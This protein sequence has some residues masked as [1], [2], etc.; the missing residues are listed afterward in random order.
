[1]KKIIFTTVSFVII[2]ITTITSIFAWYVTNNDLS[3]D[4]TIKMNAN[5]SYFGG[6]KGTSDEPYLISSAKHLYNLAWLQD[7][8][9]F[10]SK[11]YYFKLTQNIDMSNLKVDGTISPIPTIGIDSH[12]FIGNFNGNG[13]KIDNLYV[14]T[15]FPDSNE[16]YIKPSKAIL[17]SHTETISNGEIQTSYNGMFGV[18]KKYNDSA[19]SASNVTDFTIANAKIE[20]YKNT[21]VGYICGYVNSNLSQVGVANSSLI[22]GQGVTNYDSYP[23][24][25]YGLIGDYNSSNTGIDWS[26]NGSSNGSDYGTSTDIRSLFEK[27]KVVS[28]TMISSNQMVLAKKYAIPFHFDSSGTLV[29]GSGTTTVTSSGNSINASNAS[30]IPVASTG[31][32]IG[33][34]SGGEIKVNEDYFDSSKVDFDKMKTA[35]NSQITV[36][37]DTEH[38]DKIKTY[39]KTPVSSDTTYR[40]G[41]TAMVLSGTSFGDGGSSTSFPSSNDNYLVVNNAKVGDW[42]GSLFIP[43]RGIWV[44]PTKPGR[45]EFVAINTKTNGLTNASISVIRLKRS[46]PK[47]YSTGFSNTTYKQETDFSNDMCGCIIYGGTNA[48]VPY[49]FG[50]DV[51]QEDIDNGYEFFITKYAGDDTGKNN[52]YFVY[53]DVGTNSDS[54]SDSTTIGTIKDIDYTYLNDDKSSYV[55]VNTA[56]GFTL[57]NVYFNIDGTATTI[58]TLSVM[59]SIQTNNLVYYYF[60]S[61]GGL[62]IKNNGSG[63]AIE[64]TKEEFNQLT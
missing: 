61:S 43:A 9:M 45:F 19:D 63:S 7:I 64:K 47:D 28:P 31:T 38:I 53:L 59:R 46:T 18:I 32:N 17:D 62:T 44:A 51:T 36:N 48:Y 11:V 58:V 16:K 21:L 12:P 34:Y 15:S 37:S 1:M 54:G 13:F 30:T 5:S 24:S 56:D 20:S 29:S 27:V 39:L 6:G 52:L 55:S 14:T 2:L 4:D 57:S 3:K 41:D 25:K 33:Y 8:G 40:K 42:E 26:Q 49:Y 10:D 35:G 23:I 22:I 60:L 50:V